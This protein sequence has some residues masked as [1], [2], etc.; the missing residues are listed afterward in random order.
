[1][2]RKQEEQKRE[3]E[4]KQQEMAA[5]ALAAAALAAKQATSAPQPMATKSANSEASLLDIPLPPSSQPI[6]VTEQ[7]FTMGKGVE[8]G[9]RKSESTFFL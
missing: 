6:Q 8:G 5:A 9:G 4:R 1:M 7:S 2:E 3:F